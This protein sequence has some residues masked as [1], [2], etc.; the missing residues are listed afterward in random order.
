[1]KHMI[2]C[3]TNLFYGLNALASRFNFDETWKID[4]F[5]ANPFVYEQ[6]MNL[7]KDSNIEK[8]YPR[9]NSKN[10][11]LFNKAVWVYDGF[12]DLNIETDQ[13]SNVA[14]LLTNPPEKDTVYNRNFK[15]SKIKIPCVR[16][17]EI[18]KQ[19]NSEKIVVKLDVEGAEFEII[20]DL[21]NENLLNKINFFYVEFHERF[22]LE[23]LN[24]YTDIKNTL[25]E[26]IKK[27]VEFF[28]EWD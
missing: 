10:L 27:Q 8:Y 2:D 11:N 26:E 25:V 14:N 15:W 12:I 22:F 16:L 6:A 17:S 21:I 5:E 19:S 18:I 3:G 1:M 28:Q 20:Q 13:F 7:I 4:C 23:E 9:Y 24:K